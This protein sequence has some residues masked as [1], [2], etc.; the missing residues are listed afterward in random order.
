MGGDNLNRA[1]IGVGKTGC[2]GRTAP[3]LLPPFVSMK[4][5]AL[6]LGVRTKKG[7]TVIMHGIVLI[8]SRVETERAAFCS[9]K[10]LL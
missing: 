5:M 6:L 1:K 8:F 4:C 7:T 10:K 2:N 9:N 3:W